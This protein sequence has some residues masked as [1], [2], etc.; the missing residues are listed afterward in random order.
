MTTLNKN[1]ATTCETY[2]ERLLRSIENDYTHD[3]SWFLVSMSAL[4]TQIACSTLLC[5]YPTITISGETSGGPSKYENRESILQK[6]VAYVLE[7]VDSPRSDDL[8]MCVRKYIK[9]LM[10]SPAETS[11]DNFW[12]LSTT[13]VKKWNEGVALRNGGVESEK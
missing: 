3:I 10:D 11:A 4:I 8:L 6:D 12:M 5:D 9:D 13:L 1:D 7:Q 2:K